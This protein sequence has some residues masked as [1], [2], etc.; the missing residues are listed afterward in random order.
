MLQ[1]KAYDTICGKYNL[2]L[3]WIKCVMKMRNYGREK[4]FDSKT[5]LPTTRHNNAVANKFKMTKL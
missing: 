2:S 4:Y 5:F 3:K 1:A